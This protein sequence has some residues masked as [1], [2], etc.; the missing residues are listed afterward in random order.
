MDLLIKYGIDALALILLCS[1]VFIYYKKGAVRTV[2]RVASFFISAILV[3]LFSRKIAINLIMNTTWFSTSQNRSLIFSLISV[4]AVF[5]V[6]MIVLGIIIGAVDHLFKLPVL[7]TI[8]KVLGGVLGALCGI[9]SVFIICIILRLLYIADIET[10]N[11]MISASSVYKFMCEMT[12]KFF[13]F[14]SDIVNKL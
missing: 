8:N 6:S 2:L 4:I 10:L 1:S 14:I 11:N 5:V 7:K 13:P 9:F 3:R 12:D